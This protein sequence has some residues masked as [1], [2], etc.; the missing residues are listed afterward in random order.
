MLIRNL[1][2]LFPGID[3]GRF[4]IN[5]QANDLW[6]SVPEKDIRIT[7]IFSSNMFSVY[8]KPIILNDEKASIAR[9]K[10]LEYENKI[11]KRENI[12]LANLKSA[13][14]QFLA[15]LHIITDGHY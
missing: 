12:E 11:L 15:V 14:P 7:L 4:T 5:Y 1:Y 3:P 13:V 6:V 2:P 8:A 9:E 10:G